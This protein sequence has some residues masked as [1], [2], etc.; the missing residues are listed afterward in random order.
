MT[1]RPELSPNV[2]ATLSALRRRIRRYI[3]LEGIAAALAWLGFAFW[4]SLAI[5]WFLEPP[6][7][8]RVILLFLVGMGLLLLVIAL[9]GRRAFV[10][11]TDAN[12]AMLLERR[13]PQFRDSLLTSV[14][15]ADG[16]VHSE[17]NPY[18]LERT[19]EAASVPVGSVR[20][21]DVFNPGPL[22]RTALAAVL[23]AVSIVLL[24]LIRPDVL[25]TWARRSLAMSQELWPRKCRLQIVGFEDGVAKIAKGADLDVI[26]KAD[27]HAQAV[28]QLVEIVYRESGSR[29]RKPMNREG[30]ADPQKDSHQDF[31][32]TFHSILSPITFDV[33]GGDYRIRDLRVQ[34]VDNPTIVEMMLD[35]EYPKYMDR[36]AAS[37]PSSGVMQFPVGSRIT[38]RAR[39]NKELVRVQIDTAGANSDRPL[40]VEPGKSGDARSFEHTLENLAGDTTLLFTLFDA[41]GIKSR[42]PIRLTISALADQRPE[43]ALQLR[44]IGPAVTPQVQLPLTG[45]V[46]D[47]YGLARVWFE[48]AIDKLEPASTPIGSPSGNVTELSLE[49]ETL[50]VRKLDLKPGQKLLV[51]VKAEDRHDLGGGPNVGTSDRWQLD[52]VT[53]DQLRT[54]LQARELVLRQRFEATIKDVEDVRDTL[55]KIDFAAEKP[56]AKPGDGAEPGDKPDAAK[57]PERLAAQRGVYVQWASQNSVKSAHE[58]LGLSAAFSDIREELVNNRIDTEEL[59]ARLEQGI[60]D[61]LRRIGDEMFAELTR[62]LD[63]LQSAIEETAAGTEARNEAIAQVD[64]ILLQMRQVLGRMLELEDFNEA[65]ELLRSIIESQ[66][67]VDDETQK[68]HKDS[69]RN[70]LE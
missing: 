63:K 15:L 27:L 12:M 1:D 18:L 67:K 51:S 33:V 54:M 56:G 36:P 57:S 35:C 62:R 58:V 7:G 40:Y 50:D 44:G 10:P 4:A 17:F 52:V 28:P 37:L 65:I 29:S 5:D 46:T 59:K 47:D 6:V 20:L 53:P 19:Y 16:K 70:L 49:K 66:E 21:A 9:I 64:A 41:D 38:L 60:S 22:R 42:E 61:P 45:K 55:A 2:R 68:R 39:S 23:F 8:F 48:H 26:A 13:F 24:A 34:V 31:S 69:I 14:E 3:W 43:F 32:Y 25:N 11:L 30:V